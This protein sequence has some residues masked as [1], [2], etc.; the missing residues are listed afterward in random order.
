MARLMLVH[1]QIWTPNMPRKPANVR[2]M[3]KAID[4]LGRYASS[5]HKLGQIL[6][7]FANRKLPDYDAEDIDAAIQQ[8]IDQCSQLGYVDDRQ[9]AVTV[10]RSERRL[11][12]SQSVIRRRLRQHALSE[13]IITYAVGEVDE[14]VANGEL[15]AAIR[16]AQR[17]RLG[18]FAKRRSSRHQRLKPHQWK[19]RDLGAM[20]R[21]G[22]PLVI[23]QQV[24]DHDDPDTINDLLRQI[25]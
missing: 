11:G 21:A 6:Q 24:L 9:F 23:S 17:R 4:Y 25:E 15:Q 12:R 18:P 10:A 3:N 22:F 19:K 13:D 7:R 5:R 1:G 2:M 16:F 14:N 8:T 20:A